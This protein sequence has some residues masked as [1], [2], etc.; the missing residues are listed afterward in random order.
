MKSGNNQ[1]RPGGT[2]G[3]FTLVEV[4]VGISILAV[5]ILGI[6]SFAATSQR[7]TR[8][9]EEKDAAREALAAKLQEVEGTPF[10]QI[11]AT[12]DGTGFAVT[13]AGAANNM[14]RPLPGD[15]DGLPGSV[16]VTVPPNPGDP[17]R[18]LQVVV[19]VDWQGPNGPR[20]M[21]QAVLLS[22]TGAGS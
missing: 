11:Q 3:G 17:S 22:V 2:D 21:S 4:M 20:S 5:S 9:A 7:L 8:T 10:A 19:R 13:K 12:H 6:A 18:L 16:T 14:L 1:R 15:A